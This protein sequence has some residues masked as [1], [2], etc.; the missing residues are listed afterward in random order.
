L[1][2]GTFA[3]AEPN[4][5][6]RRVIKGLKGGVKALELEDRESALKKGDELVDDDLVLASPIL[7]GFSLVDKLWSKYSTSFK[8]FQ[9]MGRC[10][11]EFNVEHIDSI[12]WN[13][14]IFNKI[15]MDPDRKVLI[16][17]LMESHAQGGQLDDLVQGKGLGLVINLFGMVTTAICWSSH[18]S[19]SLTCCTGPPGVGKTLTVEA[20]SERASEFLP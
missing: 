7:Y 10:I 14:E 18:Y 6:R 16:C 15:A 2:P 4:Y 1:L 5:E 11:V 12:L 19:S 3:D 9:L 17:S 20:I 8:F 13:V